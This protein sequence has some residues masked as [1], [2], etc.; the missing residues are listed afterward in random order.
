MHAHPSK[1]L[2]TLTLTATPEAYG[3]A[4][5]TSKVQGWSGTTLPVAKD[6]V[7]QIYFSRETFTPL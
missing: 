1:A 4:R 6:S 5:E 3:G 2:C 7:V